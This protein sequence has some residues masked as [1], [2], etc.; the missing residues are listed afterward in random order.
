MA[1]GQSSRGLQASGCFSSKFNKIVSLLH[2]ESV[3][4]AVD[5]LCG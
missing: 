3:Q 5:K 2:T 4:Q 1:S